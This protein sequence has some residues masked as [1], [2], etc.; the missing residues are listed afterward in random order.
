MATTISETA[1]I[2]LKSTSEQ[3]K[4]KNHAVEPPLLTSVLTSQVLCA[5]P[6]QML[7]HHCN[8]MQVQLLFGWHWFGSQLHR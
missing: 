3:G 8:Q 2:I 7:D 6:N 1:F 4:R 5:V